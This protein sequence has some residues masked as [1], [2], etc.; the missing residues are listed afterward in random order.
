MGF[1]EDWDLSYDEINELLTDNPSLRSFVMGYAAEV[2]CKRMFFQDAPGVSNVIKYDDHDRLKKGDIAFDYRDYTLTVEVK[3]LQSNSLRPQKRTGLVVPKFQCDASDSRTVHFTDGSSMV[4]TSLL[5]GQ[6]DLLA[7]NLHALHHDWVFA[8]A[9]NRDLPT[10]S[11][12][13]GAVGRYSDHQMV[14]LLQG[15]MTMPN[16]VAEPYYSDPWPILDRIVERRIAAGTPTNTQLAAQHK[17][18]GIDAL[19]MTVPTA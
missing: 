18:T 6:F 12:N 10:V 19:D 15:T 14:S 5:V 13:R 17:A 9:D 8:F 11:L 1:L 2:K 16:P 7:V 4:T 3:S